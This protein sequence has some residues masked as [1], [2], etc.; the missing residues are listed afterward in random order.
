MTK[1]T[2]VKGVTGG[3]LKTKAKTDLK[4][5]KIDLKQVK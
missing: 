4:L 1:V 5:D 3:T 2:S